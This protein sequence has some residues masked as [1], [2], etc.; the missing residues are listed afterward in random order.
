MPSINVIYHHFPHYRAPV[1]RELSKSK[2]HQYN[3]WGDTK[4]HKGIEAFLGDSAVKIH[5]LDFIFNR[6]KNTV[7]ISGY[8]SAISDSSTDALVIIGNPNMRATWMMAIFGR[9]MGKRILFWAHGWIKSEP[10]WKTWLRNFYFGLADKV[11]VYGERSMAKAIQ[12]GFPAKKVSVIYNSLD[13]QKMQQIASTT[14]LLPVNALKLEHGIPVG[15]P[16]LICTA[17]LTTKCRFDLLLQAVAILKSANLLC[18]AVLIGEG[19]EYKNLEAMADNLDVSV[20][21]TGAIYDEEI[22]AKLY[23]CADITISPGKVGLTA[24]HSLT[25]GVPVITHDNFNHQMPEFE[26]IEAGVTGSFFEQ[27]NAESLAMEIKNWLLTSPKTE[28]TTQL[29][30]RIIKEKFNPV[31]QAAL[32]DQAICEV[33]DA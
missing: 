27:D 26:V 11:L 4:T 32:I 28:Q 16:I 30:Q 5:H 6:A 7:N 33:F 23:R 17:R 10:R 19:P 24:I 1:L 20:H 12:S 22:L 13:W 29:C 9:L 21:F 31:N 15:M 2:I 25:Y 3:F 18:G 8:W 14:A